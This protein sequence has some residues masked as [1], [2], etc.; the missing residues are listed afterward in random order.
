MPSTKVTSIDDSTAPVL[1]IA[2]HLNYP[3]RD[4]ADILVNRL[5]GEL[6]KF[7]ARVDII[8]AHSIVEYEN[9]QIAREVSF[10]NSSRPKWYAAL[11]TIM[12]LS[13]YTKERFLT[14]SF[15]DTCRP[16]LS[17]TRY[18]A[19]I[20]SY[21]ASA[22]LSKLVRQRNVKQY[23]L[24]H[25]DDT[26]IYRNMRLSSANVLRK[27]TAAVSERW[28]RHF[29]RAIKDR[30]CLIHVS[31][32]DADGWTAAL[33]EHDYFVSKVGCDLPEIISDER[34]HMQARP[35]QIIFVGSLGVK[36]NFDAVRHFAEKFLPAIQ[37]RVGNVDVRI[38][39][40]NPT[41]E[42]QKICQKYGFVLFA[43]VSDEELAQHFSWADFSILPFPY[44]TGTKLKLL[45]SI[46]RGIPILATSP[47]GHFDGLGRHTA[48]L[49]SDDPSDWAEHINEWQAT[50]ISA[51]V[52]LQLIEV[53]RAWTWEA[54]ARQF[55]KSELAA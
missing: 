37:N 9:G 52:R 14:K 26:A 8:T 43:N 27:L 17:D 41:A 55:F 3:T 51:D 47:I 23:V 21:L 34:P 10:A 25:N 48:C 29:G 7:V 39:G 16:F 40:S 30:L 53:A 44:S 19:I 24:T 1:V 35:A 13:V 50:D 31:D 33:G 54:M 12:F 20:Y 49:V 28:V 46:S 4:G 36:M 18:Q 11:R 38:V 45:D 5:L 22:P 2:P 6:S 15:V 32:N 42:M